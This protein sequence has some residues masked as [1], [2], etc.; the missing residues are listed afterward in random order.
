MNRRPIALAALTTALVLSACQTTTPPPQADAFLSDPVAFVA[1]A[2]PHSV[3]ATDVDADGHLD[4]V[5][6]VPDDDAVAVLLG[7]GGRAFGVPVRYPTGTAPKHAVVVDLDGDGVLDLATANQDSDADE[8]VSVLLGRPTGGYQTALHFGACQNPHYIAAGDLDGDDHPD[9]AVACWGQDEIAVL[10]GVG[11]G[12]FA[13]MTLHFSGSSPH[14][15]LIADLDDDGANDIAVAN[16]G[17]STIGVHLGNGDGT[18]EAVRQNVVGSSPHGV[19]VGDVNGDAVPDLVS[20]NQASDDVTVL[21]GTGSGTFSAAEYPTG[22]GTVPKGVAIGDLDGD[23]ILDLATANSHGNHPSGSD[24]T[25]V[26]VLLGTGGGAFAAP[27]TYPSQLTPFAVAIADLDDDGHADI[28]TANWHSGDAVVLY[29]E[30]G[31]PPATSA[32]LLQ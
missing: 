17:A 23:G 31:E 13:P 20:V 25:S 7:L 8:D 2:T 9:L 30:G 28:V 1:G 3:A 27:S 32:S 5:V 16:L 22:A 4:L 19:A 21:L 29:G 15:L 18:F 26:S 11:D 10:L 14:A 12:T 6:A 24:P